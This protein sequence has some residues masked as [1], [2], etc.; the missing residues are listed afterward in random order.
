MTS[1]T[2]FFVVGVLVQ[3]VPVQAEVI[4]IDTILQMGT[5]P[6][7]SYECSSGYQRNLSN[8]QCGTLIPI[9][10]EI[11]ELED[12]VGFWT[13][14]GSECHLRYQLN[15]NDTGFSFRA[16]FKN[17]QM[18]IVKNDLVQETVNGDKWAIPDIDLEFTTVSKNYFVQK[19]FKKI[20]LLSCF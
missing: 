14:C 5:T 3:L 12:E 15:P 2:L 10:P 19:F 4:E 8:F 6:G 11:P 20:P 17:A 13:G 18:T 7:W 9:R 16:Y 1:L